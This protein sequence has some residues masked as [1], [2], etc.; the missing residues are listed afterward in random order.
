MMIDFIM[1]TTAK[2]FMF[3]PQDDKKKGLGPTVNLTIT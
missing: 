2:S 1:R 3:D